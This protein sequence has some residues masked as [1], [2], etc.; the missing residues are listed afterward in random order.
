[1]NSQF[2]IRLIIRAIIKSKQLIE[3]I[4]VK[5]EN[6][7]TVIIGLEPFKWSTIQEVIG[8][9][10]LLRARLLSELNNTRYSY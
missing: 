3:S 1:M 6:K 2:V 9:V 7:R 5:N 10:I 4:K 8:R